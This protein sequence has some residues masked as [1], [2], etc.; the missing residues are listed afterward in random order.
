MVGDPYGIAL[1]LVDLLLPLVLI[2]LRF[3]ALPLEDASQNF[4]SDC[5]RFELERSTFVWGDHKFERVP[6]LLLYVDVSY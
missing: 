6:K 5:P 3:E 2:K 4:I 1:P